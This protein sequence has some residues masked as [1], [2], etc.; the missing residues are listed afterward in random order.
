LVWIAYLS[1]CLS[2]DRNVLGHS[3]ASFVLGAAMS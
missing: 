2:S 1:S 3:S